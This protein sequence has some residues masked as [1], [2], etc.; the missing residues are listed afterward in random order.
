VIGA[1]RSRADDPSPVVREHVVWALKRQR[2]R[3]DAGQG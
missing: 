1:L 3:K 2:D